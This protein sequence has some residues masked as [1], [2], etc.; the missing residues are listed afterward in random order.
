MYK[1]QISGRSL[2]HGQLRLHAKL[3]PLAAQPHFEL[4]VELKKG[5][6]PALNDLLRAYAGIDASRGEFEIFGQMAMQK[7]HYEGYV[8]PFLDHV[9]FKNFDN[10]KKTMGERIWKGA[11]VAVLELFKNLSLIHI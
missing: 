1:R 10:D 2:G 4:A 5:S 8:K 9:D 11:A 3:E 6:L 7:G